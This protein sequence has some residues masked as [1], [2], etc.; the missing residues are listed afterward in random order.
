[1]FKSTNLDP[2]TSHRRQLLAVAIAKG[3]ECD[4]EAE[5]EARAKEKQ[6]ALRVTRIFFC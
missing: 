6:R 5:P 2:L 4:I 3:F 1:L